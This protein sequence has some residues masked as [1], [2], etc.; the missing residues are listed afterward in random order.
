MAV[1]TASAPSL[2]APATA[3]TVLCG[4]LLGRRGRTIWWSLLPAAA[5]FVPFGLSVLDKPRALL[6]D[7]GLPL[8]FDAAPL[9]QQLLGQPLAFG[10]NRGV[11]GLPFFQDGSLPWAL[12]LALL[13][14]GPVLVL[15]VAALFTAGRRGRLAKSLWIAGLIAL[16]TGWLAS[17]VAV[18]MN[19][20]TL[21]APFT[22]PAVSAAS[23]AFLGAALVG[24]EQFLGAADK[25]ATGT[26]RKR[27]AARSA[28]AL[29]MVLLLVGPLAGMAAWSAV[30][31]LRP[32]AVTGAVPAGG[33]A[34]SGSDSPG[35]GTPRLVESVNPRTLPATAID[36]G[37]GPEQT[38]TLLISTGENG[39][40]DAALM[41]GAGTT[42]DSLS[43]VASA[44]NILGAPGAE[45]ARDDDDVTAAVRRVVATLVAGQGVDPRADLEQL[46]VGF[47]VLGSADTAA[48][49]TASR[50]DA[51]PG[52]VAVGQTDVGWLWRITPLNQPVLQPA[53]IAHRA[54]IVDAEGATVGLVPSAY[55]DVDAQVPAGPEGRLVVLAERADTGWSAW[56]DGRK[57]TST[58]SGWSQAFTLPPSGGQLVV[59][60]ENP[61]AVWAG[62][63]QGTVIGLTVMLA[64]PMPARRPRPGL[65][66]DEGS[67][68]KEHQ[69]A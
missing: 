54:R 28:V 63:A 22:G 33:T 44:R 18:A 23:F 59:R 12:L 52:L 26:A 7:P 31:V 43:A 55:N 1:V 65:S 68:R 60:Y 51:V 24:A 48:Q 4:L 30:N 62:I 34:A 2:L 27:A 56:L 49:L 61:W 42:L 25:A 15:A 57:L 50:M 41:R 9:W 8:G 46:G 14:A 64:I 20:D 47:V 13:I 40:F 21:V 36:R 69:D 10:A 5:L 53:D 6:A 29:G 67:L 58:T 11:D 35:W 16:A 39:T 3:V 19:A 45:T 38:R 17:R 32:A 37:T 66:R